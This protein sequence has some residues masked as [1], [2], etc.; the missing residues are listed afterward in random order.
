MTG[1]GAGKAR[2]KG[3]AVEAEARSV[4]ARSLKVSL[5]TPSSLSDQET[6]LEEAVRARV[7]R[8]TVNLAV[9]VGR[10]GPEGAVRVRTEVVEAAAREIERLRKKGLVT[11]S[12]TADAVA[13]LPGAFESGADEPLAADGC[14]A[15]LAAVDAALSK[16]DGMR[17]REGARLARELR[18]IVARLRSS[19]D[20]VALRVPRVVV[21]YQARL[22]ERVDQLLRA[23]DVTLDT[24]TLA[25]EVALLAER[26]DVS[27]EIARLRAHLAEFEAG[28]RREGEVGRTL[29]FLAQELLR[30]T[31]TIGS[32]SVDVEIGRHV[33]AM[34]AEIDRLKEQVANLE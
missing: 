4:N 10:T 12:L 6:A 2:A 32:K 1:Y 7:R 5:R 26:A 29:E 16:L 17:R 19:T 24:Q 21:E 31:N 25:R 14:R 27:E 8:G 30:E 15:V 9:R 13:S 3:I 34:K 18:A 33:V 20:A 22:K 11:G 23:S 28:L